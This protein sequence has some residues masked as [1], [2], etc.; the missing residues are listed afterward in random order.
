MENLLNDANA[1]SEL[2]AI[3]SAARSGLR[4]LETQRKLAKDIKELCKDTTSHQYDR[5]RE[6][7][8]GLNVE[9]CTAEIS[10]WNKLY[11]EDQEGVDAERQSIFA[12]LNRSVDILGKIMR[13]LDRMYEEDQLSGQGNRCFFMYNDSKNDLDACSKVLRESAEELRRYRLALQQ[14]CIHKLLSRQTKEIKNHFFDKLLSAFAKDVLLPTDIR[15][16]VTVNLKR[17]S[18][19]ISIPLEIAS[20]VYSFA[21]LESCVALREVSSEWYSSF[22]HMDHVLSKKL[23][24]R[25]PWMQPGDSDLKTW[26]DCVLVFVARLKWPTIDNLDDIKVPT[27]YESRAAVLAVELGLNE[28]LPENFVSMQPFFRMDCQQACD[29][30][31]STELT[32]VRHLHTLE[33]YDTDEIEVVSVEGDTTVLDKFGMQITLPSHMVP[34]QAIRPRLNMQENSVTV[35]LEN[36]ERLTMPRENAHF[37]NGWTFYVDEEATVHEA[38]NVLFTRAP[39]HQRQGYDHSFA[40]PETQEM[41]EHPSFGQQT[42]VRAFYNGLVWWQHSEQDT[43]IPTFVDQL[44]P[45]LTYYK[46]EKIITGVSKNAFEQMSKSRQA[47][48]LVVSTL[49]NGKGAEI[50]NLA[51]G[52]VTTVVPPIEWSEKKVHIIPG[53]HFNGKFQAYMIRGTVVEEMRNQFPED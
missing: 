33:A 10:A 41:I 2:L 8:A 26:R 15:P 48:H 5:L 32:W 37:K 52:V 47:H 24:Q 30:I 19:A 39:C 46:P 1:T 21:D 49:E 22:Q 36:G 20:M 11:L 4:G 35:E 40:D 29:H 42:T 27:K 44:N 38:G 31:H 43:L 34:T 13:T 17:T 28:K 51:T 16:S 12:R 3:I 18:V 53:Y 7:R 23:K 25:N 14:A 50:V 9:E 6:I 45:K